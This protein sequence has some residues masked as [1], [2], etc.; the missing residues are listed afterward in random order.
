MPIIKDIV[1]GSIAE[2]G[3]IL[4]GDTLISINGTA[5]KDIFDYHFLSQS[6]QL[7]ILQIGRAH[8]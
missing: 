4:P 6:S 5:I 8:V 7:E 1:D 3:G 2:E